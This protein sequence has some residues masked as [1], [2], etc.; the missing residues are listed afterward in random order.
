VASPEE[1]SVGLLVER[2]H[3][4]ALEPGS[5]PGVLEALSATLGSV[6]CCLSIEHP[7]DS[8][9]GMMFPHGGDPEAMLLFR[10]HYFRV[11][12]W[13]QSPMPAPGHS[14]FGPL[15]ERE[16]IRTEFFN[17]WMHPQGFLPSPGLVLTLHSVLDGEDY[18]GLYLCARW[19]SRLVDGTARKL[20]ELLAPHLRHAVSVTR[21]VTAFETERRRSQDMFDR[22]PV[23]AVL[24]NSRGH[25]VWLNEPCRRLVAEADGIA[26]GRDGLEATLPGETRQ[27]RRSVAGALQT[28]QNA[29]SG[30]GGGGEVVFLS[31][32][33][34]RRALSA[35]VFPIP[36][37]AKEGFDSD[38]C[39]G[40]FVS[41]PERRIELPADTLRRLYGLTPAEARLT[42]LLATGARLQ[43]AAD[44]LGIR[45]NTARHHL[46]RVFIKTRTGTQSSLI[47]LLLT[48]GLFLSDPDPGEASERSS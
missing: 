1:A 34:G 18:S 12:P 24:V 33:S 25:V 6:A 30:G 5:W 44:E 40:I 20:C 38:P 41:D 26:I 43:A 27:L 17:D 8:K 23:A 13:L 21:L 32:P 4:A 11:D 35:L 15:P 39:V 29:S 47:H 10:D 42:V 37:G 31:R 9:A 2:I 16:M 45:I 19:G 46:K 22:L 36:P 28:A 7:T 14:R 48:S 3:E